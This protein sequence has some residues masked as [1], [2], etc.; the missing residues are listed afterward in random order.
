MNLLQQ[1]QD[2]MGFENP[3]GVWGP[4]TH[5]R[6]LEL[7]GIKAMP[8]KPLP[9]P[10]SAM[11][12]QGGARYPVREIVVHCTATVSTWMANSTFA[13]RVAEIRRWHMEERGWKD[14]GYH[15]LIDRD[16]AVKAGR[17]ETVIGAGVEGHNAGVIHVT[18]IGGA[19]SA[20]T[21]PFERNFTLAQNAA[22]R[23]MIAEISARTGI[24][25]I[26]GHN[27]FA[28]KACPGFDVGDWL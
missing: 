6:F 17:A 9:T 8:P 11:I 28:A 27:E 18:L 2:I 12:Y 24:T 10:S 16:G 7:M 20:A 25:R 21:D 15:W 14:I 5:A 23:R 26:A 4:K 22:L 19:D 3:D 13:E 1:A